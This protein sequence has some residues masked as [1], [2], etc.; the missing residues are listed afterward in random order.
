MS[1]PEV[2]HLQLK[3]IGPAVQG[4][5]RARTVGSVLQ[6]L[7]D[8]VTL[9]SRTGEFNNIPAA[10]DVKVTATN[11]GSFEIAAVVQWAS[12]LEGGGT[13]VALLG[14]IG[15]AIRY[16]RELGSKKIIGV[17]HRP[18]QGTVIL[19]LENKEVVEVTEQLYAI[20]MNKRV[21]KALKGIVRPLG[22]GIE[23]LELT[24]G[25]ETHRVALE[26]Q[27]EFTEPEEGDWDDVV[28]R[29]T[30][31]VRVRQP[32]F[33]NDRWGVTINEG[34]VS[35]TIEDED[36]LADVDTGRVALAN[37]Q[38]FQVRLRVEQRRESGKKK[39]TMRYFIER[40]LQQKEQDEP[41]PE[42]DH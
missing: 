42:G 23:A 31:W 32:D 17:N 11:K 7:D 29:E 30:R 41:L 27:D 28:T 16:L 5:M 2:E 25:G 21:R 35:V 15:Y 18:D 3:Y 24:G 33:D 13:L 6:D 10:P 14:G 26:Q 40:V 36:F 9:A 37:T 19:T 20:I 8:L 34:R 1:E 4:E 22:N 39:P 38:S 12:T